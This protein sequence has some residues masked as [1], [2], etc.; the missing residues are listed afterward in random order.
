M[1]FDSFKNI[2][3][4]FKTRTLEYDNSHQLQG[5][6][7]VDSMM[8][9]YFSLETGNLS[10]PAQVY[11]REL[12]P[13]V[14]TL[15]HRL[16]KLRPTPPFR[17]LC[18]ILG[19]NERQYDRGDEVSWYWDVDKFVRYE[20]NPGTPYAFVGKYYIPE[21]GSGRCRPPESP[22]SI[23]EFGWGSLVWLPSVMTPRL[24]SEK[25]FSPC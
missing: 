13:L 6:I 3:T 4:L 25:Q 19:F 16:E 5:S 2:W 8:A 18:L 17:R 9:W 15:G 1:A 20:Y 14:N 10:F 11:N 22:N 7:P 21:F 23:P 12:P 24:I